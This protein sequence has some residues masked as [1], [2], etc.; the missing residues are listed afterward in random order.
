MVKIAGMLQVADFVPALTA[1]SPDFWPP[2]ITR[3]PSPPKIFSPCNM[4]RVNWSA[5]LLGYNGT[6]CSYRPFDCYNL[7]NFEYEALAVTGNKNHVN[8]KTREI[9]SGELISGGFFTPW[10]PCV[11]QSEPSLQWLRGCLVLLESRIKRKREKAAIPQMRKFKLFFFS[12]FKR[13]SFRANSLDLFRS[14]T[15][16]FQCWRRRRLPFVVVGGAGAARHCTA[17]VKR[18]HFL[19]QPHMRAVGNAVLYC[20]RRHRRR[21][22]LAVHCHYGLCTVSDLALEKENS[23]WIN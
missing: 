7:T 22:C 20:R 10:N 16:S 2:R 9:V 8:W 3:P 11:L 21:R 6:F 14:S 1:H 17:S 4:D 12:F 13:R 18:H 5:K 15:S 19:Y 23:I